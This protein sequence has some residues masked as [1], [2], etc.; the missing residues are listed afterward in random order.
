MSLGK[1]V[2]KLAF[3]LS[4]II[5]TDGIAAEIPG[6]MLPIIAITE[7]L[8]FVEGL[9]SGGNPLDLDSFFANFQPLPGATLVDQQVGTYPFANQAVAANAVIAQPLTISML[10]ICPVKAPL[11]YLAKLATFTALQA[12]LVKHNASGGT[13]T[14][15][16]PSFIYTNCLMTGMRDASNAPTA[17]AQIAWQL[18]FTKPLLT[19]DQAAAA[20]NALISKITGGTAVNGDPAWSGLEQ[21]VGVPSSLA[22]PSVVPAASGVAGAGVAGVQGLLGG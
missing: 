19:L 7:A 14:I 2:F 17:Q 16:T 1:D 21:S 22:G 12:A 10:M 11:G 5:L 3:Q 8:N 15:A 18:D 6:G 13:Y 4:P 9:L 20:E